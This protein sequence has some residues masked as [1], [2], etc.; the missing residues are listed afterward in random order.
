MK[1]KG[2]SE[3]EEE[4]RKEKK[5]K[6]INLSQHFIDTGCRPQNFIEEEASS[7]PLLYFASPLSQSHSA[8]LPLRY[9]KTIIANDLLRCLDE[10]L[11]EKFDV[12]MMNPPW[13]EYMNSHGKYL[14]LFSKKS[15][16]FLKG[17]PHAGLEEFTS[18]QYQT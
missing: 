13:E 15:C 2:R 11:H 16:H 6:M 7:D 10:N 4:D 18:I 1:R 12:I 9:H 17:F 3:N 5:L 14:S 8:T